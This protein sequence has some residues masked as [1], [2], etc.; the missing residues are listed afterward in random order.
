MISRNIEK[1]MEKT[2]WYPKPLSIEDE[3]LKIIERLKLNIE[4]KIKISGK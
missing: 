1:Q 4:A 2:N 3:K